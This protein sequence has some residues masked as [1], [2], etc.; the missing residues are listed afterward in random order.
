MICLCDSNRK[1]SIWTEPEAAEADKEIQQA[2]Q[3]ACLQEEAVW[4]S[5]DLLVIR[6]VTTEDRVSITEE[7]TTAVAAVA[8]AV[9]LL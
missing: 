9:C 1:G 5:E 7:G 2:D 3:A 6:A 4:G 8:A